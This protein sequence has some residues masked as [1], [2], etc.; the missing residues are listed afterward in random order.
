MYPSTMSFKLFATFWIIDLEIICSKSQLNHD[1][2]IKDSSVNDTGQVTT[3]RKH[4]TR[5][6]LII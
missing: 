4:P 3:F 6:L 2:D 5:Q 1:Q